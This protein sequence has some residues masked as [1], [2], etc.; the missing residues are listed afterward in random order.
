[1][2]ESKYAK[3]ILKGT[4]KNSPAIVEGLK[5]WEGIKPR[6]KWEYITQPV[7]KNEKA[8]SHDF[9]EFMCFLGCDPSNAFNFGAEIELS[10][11][12]E[13]EKNIINSATIVCIPKGLVHGPLDFKKIGRPILFCDIYLSPEYI[14][15]PA[16][17]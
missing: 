4:G 10:M 15:K 2:A 13:G 8:H 5:G 7:L 1:M 16:S 12:V 14:S 3:Y 11:G 17:K 6:M 9:D